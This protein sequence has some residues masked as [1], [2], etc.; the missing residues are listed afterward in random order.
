MYIKI[1]LIIITTLLLLFL[2]K[3]LVHMVAIYK[4]KNIKEHIGSYLNEYEPS[5]YRERY[6][7]IHKGDFRPTL[8]KEP[9]VNTT[10]PKPVVQNIEKKEKEKEKE[11]E[12]I[13]EEDINLQPLFKKLLGSIRLY[14]KCTF[15]NKTKKI[16]E[17]KTK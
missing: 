5:S 11:K 15:K 12:K 13:E 8:N 14:N 2:V 3:E 6:K 7:I 4:K 10:P 16:S 9:E 1:M 17:T